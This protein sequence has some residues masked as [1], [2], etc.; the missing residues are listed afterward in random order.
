MLNVVAP[1]LLL[2]RLLQGATTLSRMTFC[3]SI[4]NDTLGIMKFNAY[5]ECHYAECRNEAIKLSV[6][7]LSF[8]ILNV[9][10]VN[11]VM[12]NVVAPI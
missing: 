3:K 11:V 9:N 7:M 2:I 10:L 4:K 8:I 1:T 12:L 5:A 6:K